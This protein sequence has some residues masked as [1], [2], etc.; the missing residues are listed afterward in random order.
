MFVCFDMSFADI[1][2]DVIGKGIHRIAIGVPG[3]DS[4][5]YGGLSGGR[6]KRFEMPSAACYC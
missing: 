1:L 6:F 2:E 5:Y 3:D 4:F